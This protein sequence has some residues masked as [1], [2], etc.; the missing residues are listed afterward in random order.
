[1]AQHREVNGEAWFGYATVREAKEAAYRMYEQDL[2]VR[3]NQDDKGTWCAV[4][5]ASDA[6]AASRVS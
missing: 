1:M 4:V 2:Q 3:Y 6:D 5:S